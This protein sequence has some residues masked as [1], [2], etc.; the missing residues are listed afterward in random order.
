MSA[1]ASSLLTK[2]AKVSP[3]NQKKITSY[4]AP[5]NPLHGTPKPA[6]WHPKTRKGNFKAYRTRGFMIKKPYRYII[7]ISRK[8]PCRAWAFLEGKRRRFALLWNTLL[9]IPLRMRSRST[10]LGSS[11]HLSFWLPKV[12]PLF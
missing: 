11:R 10:S 9:A 5:Q 1:Q 8:A 7:D 4:M 12:P 3:S 2:K 6:T